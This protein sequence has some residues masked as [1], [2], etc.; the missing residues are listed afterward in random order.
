MEGRE[1]YGYIV[2]MQRTDFMG[3]VKEYDIDQFGLA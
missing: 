3:V 1:G 2:L